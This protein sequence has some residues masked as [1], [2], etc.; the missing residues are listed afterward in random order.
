M[1]FFRAA[2]MTVFFLAMASE[3][4]A[5]I[6][7][8][9]PFQDPARY[10]AGWTSAHYDD[11]DGCIVYLQG[12]VSSGNPD[13]S[14]RCFYPKTEKFVFFQEDTESGA[15]E[16]DGDGINSRDNQLSLGIPG[17]GIFITGGAYLKD[18]PYNWGFFDYS[19]K[20]WTHRGP[21]SNIGEGI[22][23]WG[24][25]QTF[26]AASAWSKK[27]NIGLI[28]NGE[29]SG[30]TKRQMVEVRPN[31]NGTFRTK[32]LRDVAGTPNCLR[33]RNSAIALGDW[34]YFYGGICKAS[35]KMVDT[36][37]FYR[38]NLISHSW[39]R[40]PDAPYA[41]R[42][43][44]ITYDQS[45]HDIVVYGGGKNKFTPSNTVMTWNVD[46]QGPW[47]D[48]T[49]EAKM[50]AVKMPNGAYDPK[51]GFHCYRGGLYRDGTSGHVWCMRFAQG[52]GSVAK[53]APPPPVPPLANTTAYSLPRYGSDPGIS[54][55]NVSTPP[56]AKTD[57][58]SLP[59]PGAIANFSARR[60]SAP[61]APET[62]TVSLPP[63]S[64]IST[65]PTG[66]RIPT[67]P[68]KSTAKPNSSNSISSTAATAM[69]TTQ[70]KVI[71]RDI[72]PVSNRVSPVNVAK[73]MRFT[74]ATTGD[75][76]LYVVSGDWGFADH[77]PQS[78]RQDTFAYD[79][80]SD[81][82]ERVVPYCTPNEQQPR[83][84]DEVVQAWDTK[85]NVL[86]I[87][88]GVYYGPKDACSGLA[89]MMRLDPKT[90]RWSRPE[91]PKLPTLLRSYRTATQGLYDPS[92]DAVILIHDRHT[93]EWSVSG[94]AW[95]VLNHSPGGM[96][97]ESPTVRIGRWIYVI[98]E[99]NYTLFRWNIDTHIFEGLGG[100]P[101][102]L[103]DGDHDDHGRV[104]IS[105]LGPYIAMY[106]EV[107]KDMKIQSDMYVLDTRDMA[108]TRVKL[109]D[110]VRGNVFTWHSS[111]WGFLFGGTI[112]FDCCKNPMR[113]FYL[114]DLRQFG[115][116]G[117]S[118]K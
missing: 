105:S 75:R 6:Q 7:T 57:R 25:Y 32:E 50:P 113:H 18:K 78:G 102:A 87:G 89:P 106:Q 112:G 20:K 36:N 3:A 61:R 83:H 4:S 19:K 44:Q 46:S 67:P 31:G 74:E 23:G 98:N 95:R 48:R 42:M 13:N 29:S 39:H 16:I 60:E 59:P 63:P 92:T 84:T 30:N 82:W 100:L 109:P 104:Y 28:F 38:F 76:R 53:K 118:L 93:V 21:S 58:V 10:G 8:K 37:S 64:V 62:D 17:H 99:R 56:P 41:R 73:H 52:P 115:G 80:F 68:K 40:L 117:E 71:V 43:P 1:Q 65:S 15:N 116:T 97:S 107:D 49:D 90:K 27:R 91:Q 54:T 45:T 69:G 33:A 77:W 11:V 2:L 55:D 110:G 47:R 66:E 101:N 111:G 22:I 35:G 70:P 94:R 85:R 34:V 14:V 86:W 103:R 79:I 5:S 81:K 12:H 24:N 9:G 72:P 96:F 88:P 51:T 108:Y 26:N 114:I